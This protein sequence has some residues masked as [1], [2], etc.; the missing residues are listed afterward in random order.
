M[1]PLPATQAGVVGVN[2]E[3]GEEHLWNRQVP[4]AGVHV[5]ALGRAADR[6]PDQIN[7]G[8]PA[9]VGIL[10]RLSIVFNSSRLS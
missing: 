5:V 6:I 9:P 2:R 4:E 8:G 7:A 1:R 3:V 10:E